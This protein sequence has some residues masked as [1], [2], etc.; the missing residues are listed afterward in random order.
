MFNHVAYVL[1]RGSVYIRRGE[2]WTHYGWITLASHKRL[3]RIAT[4]NMEGG[5]IVDYT[6]G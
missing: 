5:V 3:T 6:R 2:R 1:L 4:R